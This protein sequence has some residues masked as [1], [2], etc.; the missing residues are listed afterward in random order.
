MPTLKSILEL[1]KQ[2]QALVP[3]GLAYPTTNFLPFLN[4]QI[5]EDLSLITGVLALIASAIT[6]N[7]AQYR[8]RPK[9]AW[10]L[11]SF[12]LFLAGGSF[13]AMLFLAESTILSNYPSAQFL[14]AELAFVGFFFGIG[15][16]AGWCSARIL[17]LPSMA[18]N[19]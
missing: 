4:P 12:G 8:Q 7:L 19:D 9:L 14:A 18:S 10:R 11:C 13:V 17:K 16:A 6:F 2:L 3:F 15:L 5:A 1:S